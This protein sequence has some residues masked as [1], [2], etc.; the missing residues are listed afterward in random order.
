MAEHT[1][2]WDN[3]VRLSYIESS[4]TQYIDTGVD[5]TIYLTV[6]CKLGNPNPTN[7]YLYGAQQNSGSWMYNG[8]YANTTGIEYNWANVMKLNN[9]NPT[10]VELFQ[11]LSGSTVNIT[12]NGQSVQVNIGTTSSGARFYIGAC[13]G[14][15]RIY[16]N[17][18]R[19]YYFKMRND[20]SQELVRS[21]IPAKRRSN[22]AIGLYDL[23]TQTFY[24]NAGTGVYTEGPAIP[25]GGGV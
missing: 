9:P 24:L 5:E 19:I 10:S 17:T 2:D 11:R 16:P 4:G 22:N 20:P 23:V 7:S 12:A 15:Q 6:D 13:N 1:F 8:L 18:M 21:Y 14:G 3:Y 25:G